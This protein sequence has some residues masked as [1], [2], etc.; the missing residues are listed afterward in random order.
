MQKHIPT[1]LLEVL[2][3]IV[4]GYDRKQIA[5]FRKQTVGGINQYINKLK[6]QYFA[7]EPE[8][9]SS[10]FNPDRALM[11]A[12]LRFLEQERQGGIEAILN[13]DDLNRYLDRFLHTGI[14]AYPEH[15][16]E[17]SKFLGDI[18]ELTVNTTS[19]IAI[20]KDLQPLLGLVRLIEFWGRTMPLSTNEQQEKFKIIQGLL[21]LYPFPD[22]QVLGSVLELDLTRMYTNQAGNIDRLEVLRVTASKCKPFIAGYLYEEL[23]KQYVLSDEHDIA[24]IR[25]IIA[26]SK[27]Y[28]R[29]ARHGERILGL[30]DVL[31][32]AIWMKERDPRQAAKLMRDVAQ[33]L[34]S[35]DKV[36]PDILV[37]PLSYEG[38]MRLEAGERKERV[39]PILSEAYRL[40][41]SRHLGY[42]ID[43]LEHHPL[44][45]GINI[46][47]HLR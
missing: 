22:V 10:N 27:E 25:P 7:D 29:R 1:H 13:V 39:I 5:R 4:A 8:L 21:E 45:Y 3:L 37:R 12:G 24:T 30:D 34:Q 43:W 32:R 20:R 31:S 18:L 6:T 26:E 41:Q 46:K 33:K 16:A 19:S 2:K 9:Q 40:A 36:V 15:T 17:M 14:S 42:F 35:S 38:I 28:Y 11:L 23:G 44:K 47:E